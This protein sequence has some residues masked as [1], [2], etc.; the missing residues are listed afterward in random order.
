M[1]KPEEGPEAGEP[2]KKKKKS[3][4]EKKRAHAR[5]MQFYRSL[6]SGDLILNRCE[7]TYSK[8]Q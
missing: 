1:W 4:E 8:I 5:Y 3:E 7:T 2:A 6:S